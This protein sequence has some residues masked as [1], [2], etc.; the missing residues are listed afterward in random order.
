MNQTIFTAAF[1]VVCLGAFNWLLY[2]NNYD[3]VMLATKNNAT[4]AGYIYN[5]IGACGAAMLAY[6]LYSVVYMK[7][8]LCG[9]SSCSF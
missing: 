8:P 5:F 1:V 2:Q 4:N 6:F 7:Q 9:P 3:L